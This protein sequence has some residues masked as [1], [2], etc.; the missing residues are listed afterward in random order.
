MTKVVIITENDGV[1]L[2]C[3]WANTVELLSKEGFIL[4][5]L[6]ETPKKLSNYTGL[7]IP[8][9]YLRTFGLVDFVK[10]SLFYSPNCRTTIVF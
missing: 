1:W 9:W 6:I 3:V 8:L 4:A 10:L 5:G 2:N 7:S